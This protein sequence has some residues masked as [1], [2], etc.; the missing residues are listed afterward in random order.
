MNEKAAQ[1]LNCIKYF[2]VGGF[3]RGLKWAAGGIPGMGA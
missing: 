2:N 3:L 1:N